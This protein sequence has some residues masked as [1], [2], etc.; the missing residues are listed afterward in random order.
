MQSWAD[1]RVVL[2]RPH[3]AGNLGAVARV[4]HNFGL[5]RLTLVAPIADRDDRE[6]RRLSTHGEFILDQA[7]IVPD[8]LTAV[9]DCTFV[10]ATSAN[11]EGLFRDTGS[12]ALRDG[13]TRFVSALSTGPAALVFGPEPSGLTNDEISR[14]HALWHIPASPEYP[15]LN[16]AQAAAITLYELFTADAGVSFPATSDGVQ[17]A[18]ASHEDQ[19]RMFAHLREGLEAIHFLYGPKSDPLMHAIRQMLSRAHLTQQEVKIL[20]GLARQLLWA[21]G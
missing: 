3:Y 13:V 7:Q 21:A 18:P 9:A 20:H 17:D 2:V 12:T 5:S 10:A 6:A 1:T 8:L 14:C 4:M 15:A 19:E 16:L 11:V